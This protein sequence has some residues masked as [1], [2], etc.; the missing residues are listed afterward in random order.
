M[1]ISLQAVVGHP[2]ADFGQN[3]VSMSLLTISTTVL[4]AVFVFSLFKRMRRSKRDKG[5]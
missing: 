4:I 3:F 5:I 1:W 2:M